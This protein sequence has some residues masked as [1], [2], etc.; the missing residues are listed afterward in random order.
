MIA[1][2]WE[3][4]DTSTTIVVIGDDCADTSYSISEEWADE[5]KPECIPEQREK[6]LLPASHAIVRSILGRRPV[7]LESGYG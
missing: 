7:Q 1:T 2:Y 5:C 3:Q 6:F 4:S